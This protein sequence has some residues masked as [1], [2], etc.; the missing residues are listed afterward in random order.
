[1]DS[2][3]IKVEMAE[4]G[5][6]EPL[7]ITED[8]DI[9]EAVTLQSGSGE[10]TLKEREE[11][12]GGD[13]NETDLAVE[14]CSEKQQTSTAEEEQTGD[15]F[16]DVE[17]KPEESEKVK[18]GQNK[19]ENQSEEQTHKVMKTHEASGDTEDKTVTQR[20][21]N[22]DVNKLNSSQLK[23]EDTKKVS[24]LF[25]HLLP[26]SALVTQLAGHAL[27]KEFV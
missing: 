14:M 12:S 23:P 4:G 7:V 5:L 27:N 19:D 26:R 18:D 15:V 8:G 6:L 20:D 9:T 16:L 13:E 17:S 2:T 24:G 3:E 22:V 25:F 11:R 10:S 1:M 21:P